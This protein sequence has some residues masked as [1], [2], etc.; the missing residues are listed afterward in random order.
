M[1]DNASSQGN[2]MCK[3]RERTKH[4]KSSSGCPEVWTEREQGAE[5]RQAGTCRP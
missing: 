5:E 2:S 3:G 4:L 1:R